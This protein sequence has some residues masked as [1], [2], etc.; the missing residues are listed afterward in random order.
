META[1]SVTLITTHYGQLG[2]RCRRLRVKGFV[3]GMADVPLTPQNI[4]RFIDYSLTEDQS[5]NVPHE[6]LRIAA[7]LNCDSEMISLAKESIESIK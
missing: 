4:N 7:I 3:E 1:I 5:D 6:A 2:S